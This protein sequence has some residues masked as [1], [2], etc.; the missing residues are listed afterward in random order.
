MYTYKIMTTMLLITIDHCFNLLV[1]I[2]YIIRYTNTSLLQIELV[3][4]SMPTFQCNVAV[5]PWSALIQ[6]LLVVIY[7]SNVFFVKDNT[8]DEL[9]I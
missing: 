7:Q 9:I 2:I 1:K 6:L 5:F 8:Y 3:T 4:D